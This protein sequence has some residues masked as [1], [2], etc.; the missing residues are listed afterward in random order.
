MI[1]T[2]L[3]LTKIEP[4]E[5]VQP[6]CPI[7]LHLSY[8]FMGFLRGG[9]VV[10]ELLGWNGSNDAKKGLGDEVHWNRHIVGNEML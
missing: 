2:H 6:T 4:N 9:L 3:V 1:P 10:W 5:I 8:D 7:T